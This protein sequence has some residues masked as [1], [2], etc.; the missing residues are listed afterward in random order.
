[1]KID[2]NRV[3]LI[4]SY[5]MSIFL[6]FQSHARCGPPFNIDAF[7]VWAPFVCRLTL[8]RRVHPIKID[9]FKVWAPHYYA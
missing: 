7:K 6:E 3:Q 5:K 8:L 4:K 1:V 9:A 2:I